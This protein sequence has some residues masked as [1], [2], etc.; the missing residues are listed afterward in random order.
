MKVTVFDV[1]QTA[2]QRLEDHAA[3]PALA[4]LTPHPLK[5]CSYYQAIEHIQ[6]RSD[7]KRKCRNLLE[8]HEQ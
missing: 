8:M 7:I 1:A 2:L 6:P 4:L 3:E 5:I